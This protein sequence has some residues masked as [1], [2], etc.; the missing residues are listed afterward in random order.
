[1]IKEVE[2]K[3]GCRVVISGLV[4]FRWAISGRSEFADGAGCPLGKRKSYQLLYCL[5][6]Y[7]G[8]KY[9]MDNEVKDG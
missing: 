1:M 4:Y 5:Q 7:F 8:E 6:A 3:R 9:R 2:R